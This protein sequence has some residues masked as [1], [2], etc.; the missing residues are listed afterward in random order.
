MP[1]QGERAFALLKSLAY[2]RLSGSEAE[3]RA[4]NALLEEAVAAGGENAH[5]EEF[6]VQDA[7][8]SRTEFE[9]T[10]PYRKSYPAEAFLRSAATEGET[11][12]EYDFLYGE[13]LLPAN[14]LDAKGKAVLANGYLRYPGYEKLRGA[15]AEAVITYSGTTLDKEDE[16]DLLIRKLREKFTEE[17][18]A[19]VAVNL[20]A[21]DAMEIVARGAQ[22]VR[23]RVDAHDVERTSRNV[24]CEIPGAKYPD[25]IVSFGAHYD[26][27][28]FSEGVYDNMSGSVIIMELLRWFA[29]HR[30]ARTLRFHWYG[31]EEQGLLGSKAWVAAHQDELEQHVLMINVDV[32]GSVLGHEAA[33]VTGAEP[34]ANYLSGMMDEEGL[35]VEVKRDIYSSDCIPFA[36]AG[37]PAVSFMRF[38]APGTAYIHDRRDC[39]ANHFLSA[40]SLEGTANVVLAFA[41]RAANAPVFP[42]KKEIP[43][44]IQEKIDKYL[45]RKK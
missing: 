35:A 40:A 38:G 15:G 8:V 23:I 31:S 39:L 7:E 43:A 30:P 11:G 25:Q 45:F 33:V 5:I 24:V 17:F 32:A 44:D 18:G 12:R 2:E 6:T 28:K 34:F 21:A 20:R 27:V 26:S 4:A 13:D 9:V 3:E 42:I 16:T 41:K 19:A 10:A 36:D 1:I 22:R 14:L 29:E 37:V